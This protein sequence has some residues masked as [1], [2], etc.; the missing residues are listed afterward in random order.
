MPP[1]ERK[2][3][4]VR[5]NRCWDIYTILHR[6][7]HWIG[8]YPDNEIIEYLGRIQ[9]TRFIHA[10]GTPHNTPKLGLS[11]VV[12]QAKIDREAQMCAFIE[13]FEKKGVRFSLE[14]QSKN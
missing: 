8:Q 12:H 14:E 7:K 10:T 11:E 13:A 4:D 1:L 3:T 6:S 5:Y 2:I 9:K